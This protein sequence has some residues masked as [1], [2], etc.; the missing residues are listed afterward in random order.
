MP[1]CDVCGDEFDSVKGKNIHR[2][3]AHGQPEVECG[4]CGELFGITPSR[5]DKGDDNFCSDECHSKG[6][7]GENNPSYGNTNKVTVS[8]DGCGDEFKRIESHANRGSRNF[9]SEDCVNF[10]GENNPF[11]GE[12]HSEKMKEVIPSG[13]D[14]WH[15]GTKRPKH[16]ER[17]SEMH[18]GE[19]NPMYGVRGE[20]APNW[21]GGDWM[22]QSWRRTADWYEAREEALER[23]DNEC[24]DCGTSDELH[25]HH[26][27]PVNDG[28]DKF[29]TENLLTLCKEHHY[30]RHRA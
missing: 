17:M 16:A 27:E 26:I 25:V 2:T 12:S 18:S 20:D 7:S 28:G 4:Y 13:K 3:A 21:Q 9:C 29:D 1:S 19:G 30:D 22:D 24:Q 10:D 6:M 15:Y 11:Y 14:H 23:D 5:I 8:C